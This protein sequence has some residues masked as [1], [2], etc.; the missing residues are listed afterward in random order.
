MAWHDDESLYYASLDNDVALSQGDIVIAPT[1]LFFPGEGEREAIA[2]RLGENRT[3]RIWIGGVDDRILSAP[4]L[5]AEVL[6]SLAMVLPH[7]CA[8]EKEWNECVAEFCRSGI[9]QEEAEARANSE[10]GLDT[11]IMIAPF[12]PFDGLSDRRVRSIQSGNRLGEFPVV[13]TALIPAGYIDFN[14]AT[15]LHYTLVSVDQRVAALSDL[16]RAHLQRALAM[17]FAYRHDSALDEI[18][19]AV[20]RMIVRASLLEVP[21]KKSRRVKVALVLDNG[22]TLVLEGDAP[23]SEA[24]YVPERSP[25]RRS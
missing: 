1:A 17:H 19:K 3:V 22:T 14:A 16:A 15:A 20:G 11:T 5:S 2:P 13:K 18:E 9:S 24:G 12:K 25:R 4:T 7:N 23:S 8:M 21:S 10:P 6:W